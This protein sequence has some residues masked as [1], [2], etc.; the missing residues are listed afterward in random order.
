MGIVKDRLLNIIH[1]WFYLTMLGC[2]LYSDYMYDGYKTVF[3]S[4]PMRGISREE[5]LGWRVRAKGLL[6]K[7]FRVLHALRGRELF[8]TFS[9]PRTA[10]IRDLSD[11][12]ASDLV[13]VNDTK[14][15][16]SMIGTSMEVFYA[17]SLNI[18]VI[19]FGLAH[20]KDYWL[21]YHSHFRAKTLEEACDLILEMFS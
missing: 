6:D 7:K 18:P 3:L 8:E 17:H 12:K 13:L 9:D 2:T 19:I 4:G 11:I 5:S 16:C 10:V 21:N 14:V 15:D 1:G 20:E